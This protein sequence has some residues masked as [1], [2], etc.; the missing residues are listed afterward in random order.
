MADAASGAAP[1]PGKGQ[2][3][4]S[5]AFLVINLVVVGGGA[6]LTYAGTLGHVKPSLGEAELNSEIA[7]LRKSLQTEPVMYSMETFNTNLD[8]L[9]RR[10]VRLEMSVEMYDQEGFEELVTLG[11][12]ARDSIMR[13]VNAKTLHHIDNV[14]GKLKLKSE[15]ASTLNGLMS[16]GV[17]KNIYFTKFQMQ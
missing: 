3:V 6:F 10:F 11:G 14:Q 4:L 5:L 13:V 2:K 8:G 15:V 1:S 17:V 16:R 12:Q 9:P 7:D